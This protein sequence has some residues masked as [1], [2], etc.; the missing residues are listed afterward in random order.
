MATSIQEQLDAGIEVVNARLNYLADATPKPVNYAYDPPA[1]VPRQSGK[2][3]AQTVAIRNGRKTLD[4]L[5]LD[6]NGFVLVPHET[7]VK[8]FYDPDK[9][10]SVY[11]PEVEPLLNRVTALRPH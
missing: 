5:S 3:V 10:S 11:S 2:H 6:T 1:G 9:V 8:D 4:D 7:P